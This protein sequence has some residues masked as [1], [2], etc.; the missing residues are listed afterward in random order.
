MKNRVFLVLASAA[1][2]L[3]LA[4]TATGASPSVLSPSSPHYGKT[5][6]QWSQQWWQWALSIP[7]HAPPDS[8][9]VIHPL[10]DLTGAKCGVGQSGPVWFLGGVFFAFGTSGNTTF[11]RSDCV[12]P[13]DRAIFL[14]LLNT[15]CTAVEGPGNFCG[16]TEAESRSI[17]AGQ[18]SSMTDLRASIDGSPITIT[19]AYRVGSPQKPSF[20]VSLPQDDLLSFAGEGPGGYGSGTHFSPGSSCSTVDDG[21]YVMLAPLSPGRHVLNTHARIDTFVLDVT[22]DLTVR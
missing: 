5:Y 10:V 20:C 9:R 13:S 17:V 1:V 4:S 19:S 8:T 12:V 14:P 7:V 22:Y 15:E 2:A 18:A 3:M 6:G 21:Y 11:T 16:A